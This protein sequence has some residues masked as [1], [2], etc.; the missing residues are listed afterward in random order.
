MIRY[1]VGGIIKSDDT[2]LLVKK[3]KV[4][5]TEKPMGL[6]PNGIFRREE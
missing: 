4:M 3:G 5:D 1:A 2:I 6:N